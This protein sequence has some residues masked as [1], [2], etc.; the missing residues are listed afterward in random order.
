MILHIK[1]LS[2]QG[3]MQLKNLCILIFILFMI[4]KFQAEVLI[5]SSITTFLHGC[6][7]LS[8]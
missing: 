3:E 2:L 1:G 6:S 8:H 7:F 5:D 4:L